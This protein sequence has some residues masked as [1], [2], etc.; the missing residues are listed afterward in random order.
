MMCHSTEFSSTMQKCHGVQLSFEPVCRIILVR[1]IPDFL[2]KFLSQCIQCYTRGR[3]STRLLDYSPRSNAIFH[4]SRVLDTRFFPKS[5]TRN[6]SILEFTTREYSTGNIFE[7]KCI[8]KLT[9][10]TK[11]HLKIFEMGQKKT[12]TIFSYCFLK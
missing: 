7:V 3:T 6:Y 12:N 1:L 5:I 9:K 11:Y 8:S 10:L 4:Y 2:P